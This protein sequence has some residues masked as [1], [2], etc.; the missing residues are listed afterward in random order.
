MSAKSEIESAAHQLGFAVYTY[1][2]GDGKTRYRFFHLVGLPA[3]QDYFGPKSGVVTAVGPDKARKFLLEFV[4]GKHRDGHYEAKAN[5]RRA[6]KAPARKRNP[7]SAAAKAKYARQVASG[8]YSGAATT[9]RRSH[10]GQK[11]RKNPVKR[12]PGPYALFVKRHMRSVMAEGY[13]A[14]QAM[15]KIGAMWRASKSTRA[16]PRT[17]RPARRK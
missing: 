9:L 13:T 2:P 15:K 8:D 1:S 16:N 10:A 14:P 4:E 11:K 7:A 6:K 3:G 12:K 5:P 17:R